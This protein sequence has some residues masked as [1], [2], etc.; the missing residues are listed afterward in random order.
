[1]KNYGEPSQIYIGA[2]PTD[3]FGA[4]SD[5]FPPFGVILYY[6][7]QKF[8]VNY[9]FRETKENNK[10]KACFQ[11]I[12]EF[13]VISWSSD[14]DISIYEILDNNKLGNRIGKELFNAYYKPIDIVST[15]EDF[16]MDYVEPNDMD[17]LVYSK[18]IWGY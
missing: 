10:Y 3:E 2:F 16:Y 17:C 7:D 18:E 8:L 9:Y 13:T 5:V 14:N 15:I 4:T 12:N 11:E 6:E 1:L